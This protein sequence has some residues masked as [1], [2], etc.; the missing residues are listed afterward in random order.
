MPH[1]HRCL[2]HLR[3]V[4]GVGWAEKHWQQLFTWLGLPVKG[5]AAVSRDT[6]TLA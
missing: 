4:R 5:P 2:P 3:H 1:P 6:L